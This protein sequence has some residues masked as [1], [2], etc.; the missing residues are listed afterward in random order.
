[1]SKSIVRAQASVP[2]QRE[3]AIDSGAMASV[4]N[5][6][7]IQLRLP[8]SM[9]ALLA[10]AIIAAMVFA[11]VQVRRSAVGAAQERL[12]KVTGQVA[13]MLQTSIARMGGAIR[14]DAEKP[15][16]SSFL[17]APSPATRAAATKL[18]TTM[19]AS[20]KQFVD[21]SLWNERGETL[22]TTDP[23]LEGVPS[24]AKTRILGI[25]AQHDSAVVGPLHLV[26]DTPVFVIG[27]PVLEKGKVIGY[28]VERGHLSAAPNGGKAVADLIGPGAG[29]Y[30]GNSSGNLWSNFWLKAD[31]PPIS[32]SKAHQVI[33]Y[34]RSGE[35]G[36][37]KYAIQQRIAGTPWTLLV[38][39]PRAYVMGPVDAFLRNASIFGVAL[40]AL[41]AFLLWKLSRNITRPLSDLREAAVAITLG[42]YSRHVELPRSDELGQLSR[43][44]ETMALRVA[45]AQQT[46]QHQLAQM[47]ESE[48]RFRKITEASFDGI[49]IV[50]DDVVRDANRGFAEI[51]GYTV[52]EVIGRPVTD[53]LAEESLAMVR[54]RAQNQTEG[55]YEFIGKHRTGRKIILEA[56]TKPHNIGGRPGRISAF[57]DVTEKRALEA[58]FRQAQKMDAVGRLAGGVAHDFNNLLTVIMSCTDLLLGDSEEEGSQREDLEQIRDAAV[59]A[60]SLTRQLLSFSRQEVIQPRLVD[61]NSVVSTADGILK[62]L[63]GEDIE[64]TTVLTDDNPV[65]KIDK[66]QLEQV[67]VN[68]CV[69]ARDAMPKG[70]KLTIETQNMDVDEAYATSHWS[71]APGRYTVIS[72]ADTGIGMDEST[73]ARIF[74][75]FY[76]TKEVGKGTGL[77]LAMVYATVKQSG[78]FIWVYSEPGSGT[79]FKIYLPLARDGSTAAT[80]PRA[81]PPPSRGDEI[82]ILAEDSAAVRSTARQILERAGYTVLEAPNGKTALEIARKK[83]NEIHLLITDVVMPEMSGR[84]LTERFVAIRPA[85]R[86]LYMSGYTDDAVVRHGVVSAGIDYLQKPFSS[87]ALLRKVREVLDA[88]D[89]TEAA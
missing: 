47:E 30:V 40:L 81:L 76:T 69:N 85:A 78:G 59:A 39:L 9:T 46:L 44:F 7:S 14:R 71:V 28:L 52:D 33:E 43:A 8:L 72:V 64:L 50:V 5:F 86:V 23:G 70:G 54:E 68:L 3:P 32:G 74:E 89:R 55:M 12:D 36:G 87:E 31:A 41:T 57:R 65:V 25:N 18:L 48:A 1:M 63:I 11:Y 49:D 83:S 10:T 53:F 19:R 73:Q 27:A 88:P 15:E 60:A 34:T 77:G 16:F 67:V 75:P 45:S 20:T 4:T 42:D 6:Q 51:F 84:E 29:V 62:R 35:D 79:T 24:A 58:Q 66:S 82:I 38:E 13:D 22:L 26:A 37:S 61:V 80:E 21:I 2:A 56:M 17:A